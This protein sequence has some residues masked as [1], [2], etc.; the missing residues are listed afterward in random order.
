MLTVTVDL[1][2]HGREDL[3]RPVARFT[4]TNTGTSDATPDTGNYKVN[5]WYR[6]FDAPAEDFYFGVPVPQFQRI[7]RNVLEL[8]YETLRQALRSEG[9]DVE[10]K[11]LYEEGYDDGWDDGHSEGYDDG[12][13]DGM[14]E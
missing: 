13:A 7:D 5:G 1:S 2:P 3:T 9:A 8:V 14:N 6:H 12:Y 4:I 10:E 11:S